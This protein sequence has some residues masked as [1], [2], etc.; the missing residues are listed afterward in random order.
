[1]TPVQI[2]MVPVNEHLVDYCIEIGKILDQAGIRY[3]ID[4]RQQTL[5]KRIRSAEK[6]WVPY[7]LV[8]GDK[9]KERRPEAAAFAG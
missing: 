3:E 7:I 4:D 5:S 6:L 2:R 9:E 8:V 1:M